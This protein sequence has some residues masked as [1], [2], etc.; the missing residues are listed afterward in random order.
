MTE[1]EIRVTYHFQDIFTD[2]F[3]FKPS[4]VLIVHVRVYGE[5]G[6]RQAGFH[7]NILDLLFTNLCEVKSYISQTYVKSYSNWLGAQ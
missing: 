1:S 4:V 5:R 2:F 7:R 3:V 6:T